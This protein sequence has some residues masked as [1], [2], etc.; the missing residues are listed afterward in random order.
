MKNTLRMILLLLLAASSAVA[1]DRMDFSHESPTNTMRSE[2]PPG[3]I[4]LVALPGSEIE[5]NLEA[6]Y[7]PATG[8]Q[9]VREQFETTI[10][11]GEIF[12]GRTLRLLFVDFDRFAYSTM[13]LQGSLE[14]DFACARAFVNQTPAAAM[15]DD[16]LQARL[17]SIY[18]S[19]LE[20]MADALMS[21]PFDDSGTM[22]GGGTSQGRCSMETAY[23]LQSRDIVNIV[24]AETFSQVNATQGGNWRHRGYCDP[25]KN[26]RPRQRRKGPRRLED[27]R[28]TARQRSDRGT[29]P[30]PARR[31][32]RQQPDGDEH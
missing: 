15:S 1:Q 3:Y 14:A 24:V 17:L 27:P 29:G 20:S 8:R 31:M 28:R 21:R 19:R 11:E 30:R 32:A 16:Q 22:G 12:A 23:A 18:A 25:R 9:M 7:D 13:E 2:E 26:R 10:A 4:P 6:A 5:L